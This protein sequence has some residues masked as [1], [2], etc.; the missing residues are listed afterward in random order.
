MCVCVCVCVKDRE[1]EKKKGREREYLVAT[2][3]G[4]EVGL[5]ALEE[6]LSLLDVRD[7][8]LV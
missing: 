5:L 8:S 4:L 3:K 7:H 2:G 6:V 1:R